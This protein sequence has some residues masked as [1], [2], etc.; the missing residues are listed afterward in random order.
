MRVKGKGFI[1]AGLAVLGLAGF[2]VLLAS[3]INYLAGP[4][5]PSAALERLKTTW[6]EK[7]AFA[8]EDR[9]I[10]LTEQTRSRTRKGK[11]SLLLGQVR[12]LKSLH[13]PSELKALYLDQAIRAFTESR[14][15]ASCVA[16]SDFWIGLCRYQAGPEF[17]AAA[18]DHLIAALRGGYPDRLQVVKILNYIYL[19]NRQFDVIIRINEEF[20]KNRFVDADVV[21]SLGRA[22]RELGQPRKAL[23]VLK[24]ADSLP[25][26]SSRK[27]LIGLETAE[28]LYSLGSYSEAAGY[29]RSFL[30]NARDAEAED[31]RSL[32][33]IRLALSLC[34]SHDPSAADAI[35]KLID[36][37]CED[38]D[39]LKC[40]RQP[41]EN[42]TE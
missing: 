39:V 19:K 37:G 27:P 38:P 26:G 9:L 12:F 20:L 24:R 36:Q 35:R 7:K 22:W 11:F 32:A 23:E 6:N 34:R 28:A 13:G 16:E 14:M 21:Y 40:G 5:R 41:K 8:L 1:R 42:R 18:V 30:Q 3:G 2:C 4:A 15:T 29:Y 10:R 25:S 31:Y 17:Q 33:E